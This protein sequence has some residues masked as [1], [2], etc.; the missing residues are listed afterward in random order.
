MNYVILTGGNEWD[1]RILDHTTSTPRWWY[2]VLKRS[3]TDMQTFIEYGNYKSRH[4][5]SRYS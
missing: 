4:I 1:P 5:P 3:M 2:N